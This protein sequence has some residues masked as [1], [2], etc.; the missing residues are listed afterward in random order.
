MQYLRG[1]FHAFLEYLEM[2]A[3]AF[4]SAPGRIAVEGDGH[5]VCRTGLAAR[6]TVFVQ[7]DAAFWCLLLT[8]GQHMHGTTCFV[9]L[10]LTRCLLNPLAR[11]T[12]PRRAGLYPRARKAHDELHDK[13]RTAHRGERS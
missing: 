7:N 12:S 5:G 10:R 2:D 13:G 6:R 9:V 3:I 11:W 1:W 8:Q 4:S